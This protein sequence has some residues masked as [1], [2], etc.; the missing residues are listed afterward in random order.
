MSEINTEYLSQLSE[1]DF[2]PA[3]ERQ[4]RRLH[5][6]KRWSEQ[7]NNTVEVLNCWELQEDDTELNMRQIFKSYFPETSYT[8][9]V[10]R[11]MVIVDPDGKNGYYSCIDS[12]DNRMWQFAIKNIS[13]IETSEAHLFS[14]GRIDNRK[15]PTSENVPL[16][17]DSLLFAQNTYYPAQHCMRTRDIIEYEDIPQTHKS[18]FGIIE[19][20]QTLAV[21]A[22]NRQSLAPETELARLG[23]SYTLLIDDD[24]SS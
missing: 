14:E 9:P 16:F 12:H 23:L 22:S 4:Y 17:K 3:H 19:R 21:V 13:D 6:A 8:S 10:M 11:E 18:A 20:C 5:E 7:I 24:E 15:Y 1:I 2:K